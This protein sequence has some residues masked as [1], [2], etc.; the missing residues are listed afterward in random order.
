MSA[1][2]VESEPAPWPARSGG[3]RIVPTPRLAALGAVVAM[4][5]LVVPAIRIDGLWPP[6]LVLTGA[7][8]Q[9]ACSM[10]RWHRDPRR[11]GC[12]ASTP[13]S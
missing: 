10:Q 7:S 5:V 13:P 6:F 9:P 12:Y 1:A 3:A 11:C 8:W 4:V 2:V